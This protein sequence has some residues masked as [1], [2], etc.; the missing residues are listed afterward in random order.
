MDPKLHHQL[1]FVLIP[2]MAQGH[3]IPMMDMARLLAARGVVITIVTTTTT[4]S[5]LRASV[6]RAVES[7]LEIHLL[8]L[9]FPGQ[10][11]GLPEGCETLDA[12][13]SIDMIK[14]FFAAID[15][16]QHPVEQFLQEKQPLPSCII[17][18]MGIRW[19]TETASKFHIPR[20]IFH[21]TCC[22]S[23]LCV[24]QVRHY[25]PHEGI[26]S[27]SEPFVVPHLPHRIEI[28]KAQLPGAFAT[29]SDIAEIRE[30]MREAELIS[31]GVVVNSFYELEPE[32]IENY[33]K[34][35]GKKAWTIGPVSLYN[36][37]GLDKADRGK[38]ASI[39]KSQCSSW[40]DSRKPKSVIYVCFGSMC[41]LMP[42]QL[43]EI[44]LG[45]EASDQPFIWVVRNG[46]KSSEM[47]IWLTEGF[48]ERVKERGLIIRGWAPQI[49]ILSHPSTAGFLTHCGWNSTVEGICA[50]VPMITW[51]LFAEQFLNEKLVVDV[52][53]IGVSVGVKVSG[54]WWQEGGVE[55]LVKMDDVKKAIE[56]LMDE[57]EE[58]EE[59]RKKAREFGEKARWAMEEGG[60]SYINMTHLIQDIM[61][62]V[63]KEPCIKDHI[64][65]EIELNSKMEGEHVPPCDDLNV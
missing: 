53:E 54:K 19:T 11:V 58:G 9:H 47:E 38:E 56:V 16:L 43:I 26:G 48:E 52:L 57:A 33:Q 23:L 36:K 40:L 12:V 28:T 13:T 34:A 21:G 45:L 50:G 59:R 55:E 8:H 37:D 7:G 46:E 65:K 49:L 35:T 20:L 1:H 31:D 32:Y 22:F 6:D 27:D 63:L 18:D 17:S 3:M 60:S 61:N 30:K 14:K 10:E 51:P 5:R 25:K 62:H 29:A 2:L 42:A 4:A 15:M 41:R 39:N 24:H 44:G 64:T